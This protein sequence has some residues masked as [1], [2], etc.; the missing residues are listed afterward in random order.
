MRNPPEVTAGFRRAASRVAALQLKA[1]GSSAQK[2]IKERPELFQ[3]LLEKNP[4]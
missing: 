2:R 4:G 1:E 3:Q